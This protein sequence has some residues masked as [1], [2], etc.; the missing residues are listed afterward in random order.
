MNL[1][2]ENLVKIWGVLGGLAR[3]KTTAKGAYGI[4]KNKRLTEVEI[5]SIEEAQKNRSVPEG[6]DKFHEERIALCK[7]YC[8]KDGN[9]ENIVIKNEFQIVERLEEFTEKL[10]ELR[11]EHKEALDARD[12]QDQEFRDFLK[13]EVEIEFHK[14][15]IADF[16]DSMTA[17]QME[18][19]EPI[20][21]D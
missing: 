15:N 5:S 8:D 1:T 19:L 17:E 13:E 2:R 6:L 10:T 4:A 18:I 16:P 11:E 12:E 7:E 3:E 21:N 14:I 20:I 9:G